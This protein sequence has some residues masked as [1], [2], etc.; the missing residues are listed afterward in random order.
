MI[1]KKLKSTAILLFGVL[2]TISFFSCKNE[3]DNG[4]NK[5]SNSISPVSKFIYDAMSIYYYWADGM[6]DKKP[7]TKD[8]DPEKYFTSLLSQTD[9]EHGWSFIVDDVQSLMA[10]F[11]GEPKDF[12]FSL[13]LMYAN[14]A[15][16]EYAAFV[17]YVYPNTPASE[18]DIK[19][20]DLIMRIDDKPITESNYMKLFSGE[21]AKFSISRWFDSKKS[22]E[23]ILTPQNITTNPV[24]YTD[25][26]EIDG[27]KI[28][29]LFYTQFI[30]N[31]N[32]SLYDAFAK[33][34]REGVTD[35]IIDLR[36]NPGGSVHSAAYLASLIVPE[37]DVK[38]KSPFTI[39]SYNAFL[40]RAF[41]ADSK[42][43]R[44]ERLG[45]YS[46]PESNPLEANLN[47]GKVYIIA[48]GES[49][50]ASE[51]LTYCLKSYVDVVHIGGR[52]GGKYTISTTFHAY[53]DRY[54]VPIYEE[55][56]TKEKAA[57]TNWAIQPIIGIH[58]NSK[59]ENFS[60]PGYLQPK[61]EHELKEGNGYIDYWKP[62]GDTNDVFLG[63]AISLIT[64]NEE[65]GPKLNE[66]R[67]SKK[68]IIPAGAFIEIPGEAKKRAAIVDMKPA[69][70]EIRRAMPSSR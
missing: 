40:N 68:G 57:L 48:T 11:A 12:G 17:K 58:T 8:S 51:L 66:L 33:F 64:S 31:F 46:A 52:T 44:I 9:K 55:I 26:Y 6:I 4:P 14:E 32:S 38:N 3:P 34:K 54:G 65:Y 25:I 5:Q 21:A 27:K 62:I 47:L 20:L 59:G 30:N 63:K 49:Y 19:R 37:E 70:E 39:L 61:P 56:P 45:A 60:T 1:M 28:A 23:V 69:V 16:T 24:L 18:K 22:F 36:Y 43:S 13:G 50:S 15:R 42:D 10:D 53:D 7:T 67:L 29:Y 41:D 35:L 2:L